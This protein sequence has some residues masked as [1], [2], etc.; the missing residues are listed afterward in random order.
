MIELG[1]IIV[2]DNTAEALHRAHQRVEDFLEE[3]ASG[4]FGDLD[5]EGYEFNRQALKDGGDVIGCYEICPD[6]VI[7]IISDG[8][9]T[10]VVLA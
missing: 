5:A 2:H 8:K 7:W 3:F 10:T 4:N 1:E 9:T 6:E